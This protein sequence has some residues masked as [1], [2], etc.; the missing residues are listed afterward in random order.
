MKFTDYQSMGATVTIASYKA[1]RANVKRAGPI[2][3][4]VT[5]SV[6]ISCNTSIT[7]SA[8]LSSGETVQPG[9]STLNIS[10]FFVFI[11]NDSTNFNK[12]GRLDLHIAGKFRPKMT[13]SSTSDRQQSPS[14]CWEL[15]WAVYSPFRRAVITI[16]MVIYKRY[17][18]R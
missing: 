9:V 17:C 2:I 15:R 5:C 11:L 16:E 10:T 1:G 4:N 8:S 18:M 12:F 3:D 13:S 14:L 7:P 6:V